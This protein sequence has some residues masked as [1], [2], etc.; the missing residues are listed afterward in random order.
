MAELTPFKQTHLD[1]AFSLSQQIRWPHRPVDWHQALSLGQGLVATCAGRVTGTALCWRWGAQQSTLGLVIVEPAFQ[2]QGIGRQL[3]DGVLDWLEPAHIRLHATAAGQPLYQQLG[4]TASG[5]LEQ[6]QCASL[7]SQQ[8]EP[9]LPG[10]RL[11]NASDDDLTALSALDTRA[12]GLVRTRLYA[13]L[14]ADNERF[15]VLESSGEI[16][17]FACLRRFGRGLIIGPVIAFNAQQARL[18]I[19]QLLSQSV[20]QFV[21]IDSH[22]A[23]GLGH[24]LAQCGLARVDISSVMHKGAPWQAQQ[25]S[26]SCW[27]LMSQAMF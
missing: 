18:L 4:F 8:A 14:L 7:P 27:A 19:S 22:Q 20:G 13:Q 21:R 23:L 24:W 10:H 12:H 2:G 17:G 25:G 15:W 3:L 5:F 9:S 11:R 1:A 6:Y 16:V 26:V